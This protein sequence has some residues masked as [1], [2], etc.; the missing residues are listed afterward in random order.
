MTVKEANDTIRGRSKD[1]LDDQAEW[2]EQFGPHWELELS[3]IDDE[4]QG[5]IYKVTRIPLRPVGYAALSSEGENDEDDVDDEG[6]EE[7]EEDNEN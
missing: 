6:E 1:S 2:K 5:I 3:S 4:G 7:R